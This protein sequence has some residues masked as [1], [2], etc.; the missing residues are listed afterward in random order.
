MCYIIAGRCRGIKGSG[1]ARGRATHEIAPTVVPMRTATAVGAIS[2]YECRGQISDF[3]DGGRR[4]GW[5]GTDV[6]CG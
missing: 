1:H 6:G 5:V 4:C 3:T 2:R